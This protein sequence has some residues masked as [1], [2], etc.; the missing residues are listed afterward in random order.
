MD[1][2][3]KRC[4]S[5]LQSVEGCVEEIFLS[6]IHGKVGTI[7]PVCCKA[8]TQVSE[9]CWPKIFPFN[10]FFPHL[11]TNFCVINIGRGAPTAT[12]TVES[13]TK[14][15]EPSISQ[16]TSEA[17]LAAVGSVPEIQVQQCLSSL[18]SVEGCVQEV[19]TSFL[20]FQVRLVGPVCCKAIVELKD[21]CWPKIF[22][23]NPYFPPMVK[24]Y[25]STTKQ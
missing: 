6:F 9:K 21:S 3:I 22:L 18:Q 13:N 7:R 1:K 5:S 10:P 11:L 12:P 17:E 19:I 24:K 2:E 25:C 4:W 14:P 8:I 15:F 23:L 16:P 20:S